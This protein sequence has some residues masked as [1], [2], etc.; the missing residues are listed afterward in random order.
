ME[1]F[2]LYCHIDLFLRSNRYRLIKYLY[3]YFGFLIYSNFNKIPSW[4]SS[5]NINEY[6]RYGHV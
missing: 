6:F 4:E 2:L 1:L 5:L 3:L